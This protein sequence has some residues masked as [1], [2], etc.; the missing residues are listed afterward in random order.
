MG[1]F[2]SLFDTDGDEWQTKAYTCELTCYRI[3][4]TLDASELP[5]CYPTTYQVEVL[6]G[7]NHGFVDSFATVANGVLVAVPAERNW[8]LPLLDY[9]GHLIEGDQ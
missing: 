9:G 2:D 3:G 8:A 1:M 7:P 4:D 6:G 5:G